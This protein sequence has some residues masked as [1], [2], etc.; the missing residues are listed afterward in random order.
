MTLSQ[1]IGAMTLGAILFLVS[2]GP[3]V[4][5][6]S[7][8]D[9]NLAE[10]IQRPSATHLLG[11]DQYG[12]DVL[13]RLMHGGR[14]SLQASVVIVILSL[15]IGAAGGLLASGH[16]WTARLLTRIIDIL[17]AL[18]SL[19][20]ALVIVGALGIGM[21]NLAIAFIAVGWPY[22]ARLVRGF[23]R[24]RLKALDIAA[25]RVM[26]VPHHRVILTHVLPHAARRLAV[27]GGLD[28]GYTLGALA[29]FS[30]LGLGAQA[31]AAEWGL[32]LRDAQLFFTAAP[33]LL[34]APSCLI[35]LTVLSALF[36]VEDSLNSG[37]TR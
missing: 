1:K 8:T 10:I 31:P 32:M 7:P 14:A 22:Y 13:A 37:V 16:G 26:G 27:A 29:G 36:L 9:Q 2:L 11:T 35:A 25:A 19:V 15:A 33:W 30:Y 5:P 12:R 28:L 24:E 6:A 20:I 18:P 4:W 3:F 17:L 21:T 34:L 23:S